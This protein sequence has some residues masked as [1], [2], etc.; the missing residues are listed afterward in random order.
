MSTIAAGRSSPHPFHDQTVMVTNCGRRG[1]PASERLTSIGLWKR[2]SNGIF[3][4]GYVTTHV[5]AHLENAQHELHSS[6]C[7]RLGICEGSIT[8]NIDGLEQ[9]HRRSQ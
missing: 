7:H 4:N 8:Y 3:L 2:R 6:G 9:R 5:T 1:Q